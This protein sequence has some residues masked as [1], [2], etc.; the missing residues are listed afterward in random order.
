MRKIKN[1]MVESS[2]QAKSSRQVLR[3]PR[4]EMLSND[5]GLLAGILGGVVVG[6]SRIFFISGVIMEK[7]DI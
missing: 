3:D 4:E 5:G 6:R 7:S 1:G 2:F